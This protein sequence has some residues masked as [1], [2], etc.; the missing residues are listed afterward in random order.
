[1]RAGVAAVDACAIGEIGL[2]YHYDFSPRDEQQE[3]FRVQIGLALELG[4]PVIIHTREADDDTLR[5]VR[6]QGRGE[7]RGVFHCFTGDVRM[8][9][10]ALALGFYLSYAG[11]ITF[12]KAAELREVARSTPPDRLLSETDSP[13]LAPVPFRG[14]RNEPA[15]VGKVVET[16]AELHGQPPPVMAR[17]INENFVRLFG[18]GQAP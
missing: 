18:G 7:L 10:E 9:R 17:Q 1:V 8:A 5:I 13:D 6:D 15:Y 2:D 12:P 3:I 11:I 4:L 14:K 16:L